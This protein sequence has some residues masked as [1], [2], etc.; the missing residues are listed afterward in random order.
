MTH[1]VTT[2]RGNTRWEICQRP[3][4]H[5]AAN[6][7]DRLSG[8]WHNDS[9]VALLQAG[10]TAD[11]IA[12]ATEAVRLAPRSA[13]AHYNLGN[14]LAQAGRL[15]ESIE[16]FATAVRLKSDFAKAHNNLGAVLLRA[17]R[18]AEAIVEFEATLRINPAHADAR[19]NLEAARQ[20]A[21][22]K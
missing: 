6:G 7:A 11:A 2:R 13:D 8:C 1:G 20:A 4:R 3:K 21:A 19:R 16:Q 22:A 12:R 14:A 18:P 5:K 10:R 17:G 9:S 15:P